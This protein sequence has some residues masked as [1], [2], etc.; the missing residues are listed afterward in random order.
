MDRRSLPPWPLAALAAIP[1][2]VWWLGWYPG[3]AS[4]DSIDQFGMIQSGTIFD[5]HPA[6]HTLYMGVLSLGGAQPGI[7]TLFQLLAFGGLLAYAAHRLIAAGVPKWLAIGAA[8]ALGLSPAVAP[9]TITLWKDVPFGL[10]FL[11]AWIELLAQAVSPKLVDRKWPAVRLG[12]ALAGLWLFRGN[13]PIT[14]LATLAVLAWIYR[15]RLRAL[16]IPLATTAISV[17][18]VTGPVYAL[19]DVSGSPIE[20]ATVFLPDVAGSYNAEPET[21]LASDIALMDDL[22]PLTTWTGLYDCYDSTP[23]LFDPSFDVEPVRASPGEYRSLGLRVFLRDADSVLG[24]RLCAANFLYSPA[25]PEDAY[26]HRPPYDIA[27]NDVGLN[28]E[29]IS[30]RAFSA[31]DRLWRWAEVDSRLWLTWR[32]AILILPALA[33]IAFFAIYPGKRRFLIPSSLFLAHTLNVAGTS[34][35]QEFRYAYPLYLTAALTILLT[36]PAVA[37]RMSRARPS[38]SP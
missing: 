9:T 12:L 32:P 5:Y 35:A 3:F 16:L 19:A 26:L 21:F 8:W 33:A 24:H 37:E 25:H 30:D 13:G 17:A 36:W 31:T 27:P 28:R 2:F 22:A 11:W 14:V 15:R 7:V 18:L 38:N 1:V 34:P 20:P 6:A 4:S 23:L 10:F 29:A